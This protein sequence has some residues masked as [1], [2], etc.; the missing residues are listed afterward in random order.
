MPY[1]MVRWHASIGAEALVTPQ[2]CRRCPHVLRSRV[3]SWRPL[4]RV[5]IPPPQPQGKVPS[6]T[7]VSV[8]SQ[9]TDTNVMEEDAAGPE[10]GTRGKRR[11]KMESTK[12][13]RVLR[14]RSARTARPGHLLMLRDCVLRLRH[15][16]NSRRDSSRLRTN[17]CWPCQTRKVSLRRRATSRMR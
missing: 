10:E 6:S 7:G 1:L 5:R 13:L 9:A 12:N 4:P 17:R 11:G 2:R 15:H 16:T 8:A 3:P 14:R